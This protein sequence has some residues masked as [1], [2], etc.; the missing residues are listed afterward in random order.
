MASITIFV[1][2]K[3]IFV[4]PKPIWMPE[5]LP[6]VA[7]LLQRNTIYL[8]W[9]GVCEICMYCSTKTCLLKCP[10]NMHYIQSNK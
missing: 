7:L 8:S 9:L 2:L 6:P 1:N 5:S 10:S 4:T 3:P